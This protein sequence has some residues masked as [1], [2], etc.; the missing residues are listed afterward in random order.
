MKILMTGAA[1]YLGSVMSAK[2]AS[3]NHD[4]VGVDRCDFGNCDIGFKD[5]WHKFYPNDV[6]KPDTFPYDELI[7]WADVIIPL[8]AQVG[9]KA[10][11]K[12]PAD[13]TATNL[14]AIQYIVDGV[15]EDQTIILPNTN[16]GIGET[17][18]G[19]IADE[20]HPRN[21][22]SLYGQ[23]KDEA[24]DVVRTHKNSIVF[25]LATVFGPSPRFRKDLLVNDLTYRCQMDKKVSVFE[26]EKRRNFVHVED[27]ADAF[28][29]ALDK[30]EMR[31]CVFNLGCDSANTT[32]QGLL[33]K[34]GEYL[35]FEQTFD[36]RKDPDS[37]DYCVSSSYL[38]SF[39]FTATRDLD[40]G[41]PELI[42]YYKTFPTGVHERAFFMRNMR[43]A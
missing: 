28:I 30:E 40:V 19:V 43:N 6:N 10:C 16:S 36:D 38:S 26:P 29:F 39:G 27:V 17:A 3:L 14:Y 15:R 20:S 21:S 12:N 22:V 11:D 2:M 13:A 37:R 9:Q 25:R 1:G 42:E 32:K 35:D 33:D 23:L 18:P 4:V 7:S 8:A 5:Y 24:E 34:I 41:I 31:G